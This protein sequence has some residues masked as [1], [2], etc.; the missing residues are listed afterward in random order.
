MLCYTI[1]FKYSCVHGPVYL[2]RYSN[3]LRVGRSRDRIPVEARFSALFQ[4]GPSYQP[5]T[6]PNGYRD[7]DG[8]KRPGRGVNRPRNLAPRSK[9]VE[10]YT[11]A[12]QLGLRGLYRVKY[13]KY[14]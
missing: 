8:V 14:L 7:F 12:K 5:A 2:R 9:K 13:T 10:S 3:C 4:N 1:S 11:S 6:Y